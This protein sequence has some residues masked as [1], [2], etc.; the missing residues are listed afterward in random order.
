MSLSIGAYV[1]EKLSTS[2]GLKKLVGDKIYPLSTTKSATFPFVL[3]KRS[4]LTPECTKD[5]Y[6]TGDSV[7]MEVV[8]ASDKYLNSITIA[9]EV[10]KALEGKRGEYDNFSVID[11]RL[12]SA[13]E[14]YIEDTFIQNLTFTF[15]TE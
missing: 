11:A 12:S 10:R 4:S 5:R 15:I 14:D 3:Y 9:E 6:S 7:S 8:V 2:E 13:S 1:Y